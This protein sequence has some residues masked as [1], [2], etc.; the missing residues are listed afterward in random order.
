M[1]RVYLM[2]DFGKGPRSLGSKRSELVATETERAAWRRRQGVEWGGSPVSI[3]SGDE[4][5]ERANMPQSGAVP[6]FLVEASSAEAARECIR[7][8]AYWGPGQAGA[9]LMSGRVLASGGGK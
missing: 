4:Q 5:A 1:S 2:A 6:W 9:A 3:K 8:A 7:L